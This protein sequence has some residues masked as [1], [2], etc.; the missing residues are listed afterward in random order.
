MSIVGTLG[1]FPGTMSVVLSKYSF[2]WLLDLEPLG[3]MQP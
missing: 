3:A 1:F 2:I